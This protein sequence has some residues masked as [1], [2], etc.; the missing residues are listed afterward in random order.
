MLW[1]LSTP[2]IVGEKDKII[3]LGFTDTY[4]FEQKYLDLPEDCTCNWITYA[5]PE[6]K[7]EKGDIMI[8]PPSKSLP[9][10]GNT[11]KP[12]SVEI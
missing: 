5:F 6:T 12:V 8:L 3:M 11:G 10:Y 7:G 2:P 4:P 1:P 9:P